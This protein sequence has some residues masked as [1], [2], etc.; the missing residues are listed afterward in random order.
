[1]YKKRH[2]MLQKF[3]RG[4]I[5]IIDGVA[6]SEEKGERRRFANRRLSV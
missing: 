6:G 1:M 3:R 5:Q 2:A 4:G